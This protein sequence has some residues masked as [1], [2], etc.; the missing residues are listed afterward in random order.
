ML[1]DTDNYA[2][3]VASSLGEQTATVIPR[4]LTGMVLSQWESTITSD[5]AMERGLLLS[6]F[7][8]PSPGMDKPAYRA[9]V[10]NT[11]AHATVQ[12][13]LMRGLVPDTV[14]AWAAGLA[15]VCDPPKPGELGYI[16]TIERAA[17][18]DWLAQQAMEEAFQVIL[19]SEL[20]VAGSGSLR[21]RVW[22]R[23]RA[24]YKRITT[25]T[26]P[27][28]PL[29]QWVA[30]HVGP[31]RL[32]M[33]RNSQF[34]SPML[35]TTTATKLT[36]TNTEASFLVGSY[37]AHNAT[38]P[39]SMLAIDVVAAPGEFWATVAAWETGASAFAQTKKL[40]RLTAVTVTGAAIEATSSHP[41]PPTGRYIRVE[42]RLLVRVWGEG[43]TMRL[44]ERADVTLRYDSPGGGPAY[45]IQPATEPGVV[46]TVDGTAPA[47]NDKAAA[48]A[49][50]GGYAQYHYRPAHPSAGRGKVAQNE[51]MRRN[52]ATRAIGIDF[53]QDGTATVEPWYLADG[54]IPVAF[55]FP[56]QTPWSG[57][58]ISEGL[59][60]LPAVDVVKASPVVEPAATATTPPRTQEAL[61]ADPRIESLWSEEDGYNGSKRSWWAA[62]APGWTVDDVSTIHEGTIDELFPALEQAVY[63]APAPVVPVDVADEAPAE[64]PD[65]AELLP[66]DTEPGAMNPA[67]RVYTDSAPGQS[68]PARKPAPK[69]APDP[70]YVTL[71]GTWAP[72]FS[73]PAVSKSG[74]K[75]SAVYFA[76]SDPG[77]NPEPMLVVEF[78]PRGD[79][80]TAD[81]LLLE[82][83]DNL[84]RYPRP[85]ARVT[86]VWK[87]VTQ[88]NADGKSVTVRMLEVV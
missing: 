71:E 61:E 24:I 22:S 50:T 7:T 86:C 51:R 5:P 21:S 20:V 48:E 28:D 43:K 74:G 81:A 56:N 29:V 31:D 76:V 37:L 3:R 70:A 41:D 64:L 32:P 65:R 46:V 73:E 9:R 44:H 67:R 17:S 53:A 75:G 30:C 59:A 80:R 66:P 79:A 45:A 6:L 78:L 62:L 15:A 52:L 19:S 13:W 68:N 11:L 25:D 82:V 12:V 35:H 23:V 60:S 54:P 88:E 33:P 69:V 1:I 10:I 58:E 8:T 72:L 42:D 47:W 40:D 14:T 85:G 83:A 26:P 55:G 77:I 39:G 18:S 84:K 63:V 34:V 36:R 27:L 4:A 38:K 57:P 49:L 16:E 2:A 87:Q